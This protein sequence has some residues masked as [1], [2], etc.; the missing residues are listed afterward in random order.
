MANVVIIG[1][2]VSGLS[3]G[4]YTQMSGHHA[5]VCEKHTV[6]GGNLTGW[7]RGEYFIDNCIHWL[8]GTNPAADGHEIWRDLGALDNTTELYQGETLYT[9][10]RDGK[11]IS[12]YRDIDR[13]EREMLALSPRD[14]RTIRSF[15]RTVRDI[16]G[17]VGV[18]GK[19]HD[20]KLTPWGKLASLPGIVKH[21]WMSTGEFAKKLHHPLLKDLVTAFIGEEFSTF[22]LAVIV[23]TFCGENGA[24]PKGSSCAMLERITERFLSLGGELHLRKEAVSIQH[25]SG[26]AKSVTFAD[27]TVIPADYVVI[28]ADPAVTYRQLLSMKMPKRFAREYARADM[29]RFSSYHCALAC[30]DGDVPFEGDFIFEIPE[31]YGKRL[32]TNYLVVREFSHE[33]SFSP[34]GKNILQTL[35]FCDENQARAFIELRKDKAAYAEKKHKI[36]EDVIELLTKK[37]PILKGKLKCIDVWTPA[38]YKRYIGSEIGSWMSFIFP[39]RR[40]PKKLNNRTHPLKNVVFATQWLSAPGGLPI[41]ASEGK[42]AVERILKMIARAKKCPAT[43]IE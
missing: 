12:L 3:A 19:N 36:A 6:A 29:H 43:A 32:N 20:Q 34:K 14:A 22:A 30:D 31:E 26:Y 11:Q 10:E 27:G 40:I 8:T 21:H 4:I 17:H 28:T 18:A 13:M 25:K 1:G 2:G 39:P 41:A 9:C 16:Q 33:E 5:I 42:R 23:A 35:T 7:R 37:F 24:I 15:F 38:T